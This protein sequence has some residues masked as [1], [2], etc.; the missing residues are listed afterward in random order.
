M[1]KQRKLRVLEAIRQGTIGGGETHVLDL[2]QA[3]N[4]DLYEPVV[5]SFT[6]GPMVDRLESMGVRTYIIPTEKPFNFTKWREVKQLMK[7]EKIDLLHAHGTRAGSNTFW[8]ARQLG[9]PVIYTVHGWSF[10]VDQ[11]LLT[12]KTRQLGEK[13]LLN[14]ANVTVCVSES[15]RQSGLAFTPMPR[16][17]VIKNGVNL[18]KYNPDRNFRNL[19]QELGLP[20]DG[21]LV[22]CI[23]RIT[24]QK[25]PL[26]YIRAIAAVPASL[27]V[28]FLLVG[29]GELK[30]AA[31]QL[32]L[33]LQLGERLRFLEAR[34]DI[35]D[36]LRAIDIYCLP[37]LWE[38]LSIGLLEAMAMG[39]AVVATAIDGTLEVIEDGVNGLLIQPNLPEQLAVALTRLVNDAELR[40]RLGTAAREL[41]HRD[42]NAITMTRQIEEIYEKVMHQPSFLP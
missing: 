18:H 20:S 42:F 27:P 22:A 1:L 4:R 3:L 17:V 10:H 39:K 2:V 14:Q 5:L 37:S 31:Q 29:N 25:D 23:A 40:H 6:P 30:A 32:A 26:N 7:A 38:G 9:L 13:F 28:T 21:V 24:A 8:A 12:L 41:V 35:P 34:Q 33:E 11:P 16:A 36:L 19:R 15:N